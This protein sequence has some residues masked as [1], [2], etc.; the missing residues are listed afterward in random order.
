MYFN[1]LSIYI[2]EILNFNI[3]NIWF[4][5]IL[6][7]QNIPKINKTH[8]IS[9]IYIPKLDTIMSHFIW[10]EC[11]KI[12]T[13]RKLYNSYDENVKKFLTFE[14]TKNLQLFIFFCATQKN[15]DLLTN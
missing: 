9:K 13:F 4:I 1:A 3:I 15:H 7:I 14:N 12:L 6:D 10:L 2:F 8:Q 5:N 11:L